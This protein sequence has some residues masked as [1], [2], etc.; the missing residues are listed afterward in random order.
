MNSEIRKN[1]ASQTLNILN[2]G[3]YI[4]KENNLVDIKET[5]DFS[6]KNSILYR[7]NDYDVLVSMADEII[8]R[9]N[10][11]T[12]IEIT[13]ESTI[14]AVIRL[15]AEAN[16]A[17]L[18]FA[19]AKNPGGGFLGGAQA[20]EESI[21]RASGMYPCIN[22]MQEMYEYNRKLKTC[23]Y[24]DYMIFSK[25]VPV[26]RDTYDNLLNDIYKTSIITAPAV[27]AGVVK[28][29]EPANIKLIESVMRQRLSMILNV[30]LINSVETLILGAWGCGVFQNDPKN[31]AQ[32]FA[33]QLNDK[34][35]GAFKRVVFAI[36]DNPKRSTIES[37][38]EAFNKY[39]NSL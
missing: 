36:L 13:D 29:Q 5:L 38:K 23:L 33:E 30:A 18:N 26:I 12:I 4:N 19:S 15:S 6:I 39:N 3:Y 7:P 20:Q 37:F 2:N 35:K 31:V 17:C 34:Y 10:N 22:Q 1:I 16:V 24:S 8:A 21:A 32:L 9:R 28:K 27:N 25:D 14:A 11:Q